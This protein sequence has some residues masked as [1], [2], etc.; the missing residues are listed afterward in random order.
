MPIYTPGQFKKS[1]LEKVKDAEKQKL[2]EEPPAQIKKNGEQFSPRASDYHAKDGDQGGQYRT[3][4][5]PKESPLNKPIHE[6]MKAFVKNQ[7]G[8]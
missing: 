7:Y 1:L 4:Q 8:K 2:E 3:A 5:L 6:R